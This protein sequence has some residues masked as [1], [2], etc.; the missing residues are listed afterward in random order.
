MLFAE[1]HFRVWEVYQLKRAQKENRYS[2]VCKHCGKGYKAITFSHLRQKHGYQ[3]E[4]P[5][6]EYKR[7]FRLRRIL[8]LETLEKMKEHRRLWAER[9]GVAWSPERVIKSIRS[10][11]RQ[12]QAGKPYRAEPRLVAAGQ[13]KFGSWKRAVRRAGIQY[14]SLTGQIRWNKTRVLAEIRGIARQ[15]RKRETTSPQRVRDAAQRLFGSW[16][17]AVRAAGLDY[18]RFTKREIWT[19]DRVLAAIRK[20]DR[21]CRF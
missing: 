5:V 9:A 21:G 16:E 4:H 20:L 3:D 13:R 18:E 14:E 10:I 15:R 11:Y 8:S 7:K 1:P 19:V 17:A 2:V 6:W 12:V